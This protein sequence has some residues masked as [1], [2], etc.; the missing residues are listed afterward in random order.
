[1][2]ETARDIASSSHT[3]RRLRWRRVALVFG[4][5]A[6]VVIGVLRAAHA[7][8]APFGW[9]FWLPVFTAAGSAAVLLWWGA[10]RL[11][12]RRRLWARLAAVPVALLPLVWLAP[13]GLAAIDL[14]LL[15]APGSRA[16]AL[17]P[18]AWPA[19]LVTLE[20]QLA[21]EHPDLPGALAQAAAMAPDGNSVG[22]AVA[23]GWSAELDGLSEVEIRLRLMR[24]VERLLDGHTNVFPFQ[25]ALDFHF[26]PIGMF[27]FSDGL[28]V[29]EAPPGLDHLVGREIVTIGGIDARELESAARAWTRS[30]S[31]GQERFRFALWGA[32]L[33]LLRHLGADTEGPSVEL[34]LRTASDPVEAVRLR[35]VPSLNWAIWFFGRLDDDDPRPGLI[36]SRPSGWTLE[37]DGDRLVLRI[38]R[39][40]DGPAGRTFEDL[41]AELAAELAEARPERLIV[42]VRNCL[43]GSNYLAAPLLAVLEAE[44]T[45]HRPGW[46]V[47]WQSRKTFSAAVN[48]VS[49][50]RN[51]L[52]VLIVGEPSGHGPNAFGDARVA[53]L[54]NSRIEVMISRTEWRGLPIGDGWSPILPD[55]PVDYRSASFFTG[56]DPW[57]VATPDGAPETPPPPAD[58]MT[59]GLR[60]GRYSLG[61]VLEV[62]VGDEADGCQLEIT[63]GLPWSLLSVRTKIL[64]GGRL[65]TLPRYSVAAVDE[66]LELTAGVEVVRALPAA[67]DRPLLAAALDG[68][69][70]A[71]DRVASMVSADGF[72]IPHLEST[73]NSLAYVALESGD[74]ERARGLFDLALRWFPES[75]NLWDSRAD[76]LER[77]G[78]ESA[79]VEARERARE[80]DPLDPGFR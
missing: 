69:P 50:L 33:E 12:S 27:W 24:S 18:E 61:S 2:T 39:L 4:L 67:G 38:H 75:A 64:P 11:W 40:Y 48:L 49:M 72:P 63:D 35:A 17:T 55:L 29:T 10:A 42:D 31:R 15:V 58:C 76:L 5:I 28:F 44:P 14:R 30:E 32:C 19:D 22:G 62:R 13:V 78:D 45:A 6:L 54:P 73:L 79:A 74:V 57:R 80:L 51:R 34:G 68:D 3:V 8:P 47:V 77:V 36:R 41:A 9:R 20:E 1:V 25:P 7:A 46:V 37:R 60:A 21:T 23:D 66:G 52:P 43:G 53:R 59:L 56:P 16:P 26:L 71:R 65:Q 70:D